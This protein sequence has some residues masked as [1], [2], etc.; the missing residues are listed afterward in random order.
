MPPLKYNSATSIVDSLKAKGMDSSFAARRALAVTYGVVTKAAD[1]MGTAAQNVA[2]LGKFNGTAP[3]TAPGD[4]KDI[5]PA[6][7][8][9][10]DT[11][12]DANSYI[13]QDQGADF[14]AAD[15]VDAPPTRNTVYDQLKNDLEPD[16]APPERPSLLS[17][18]EAERE[19]RGITGL[20][21]QLVDLDARLADEEAR[22]R[23]YKDSVH[24]EAISAGAMAGRISEDERAYRENVDFIQRTRA[25]V[26]NELNT[27]NNA[28]EIVM[29]LTEKDYEMAKE[30]YEDEFDRNLQL[31]SEVNDRENDAQD[32]A[33]ATL[34]ILYNQIA[35]SG[36]DFAS[37]TD[38]QRLTI[39]QLE[40]QAGLP[41]G[42][43]TKVATGTGGGKILSTT[44]RTTGGYKYADVLTRHPDGSISVQSIGLGAD[45]SGNGDGD[46]LSAMEKAQMFSVA[47]QAI[48][49][50]FGD[51]G[52]ANPDTYMAV[53]SEYGLYG[54]VT[55]FDKRFRHLLSLD[56]Q[57][58]LRVTETLE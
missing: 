21:D 45:K 18:Y 56:N 15:S 40:I 54:D 11:N 46:T 12:A 49:D 14:D 41:I 32:N 58:S 9:P 24:T 26:V 50:S 29:S 28:L 47:D 27:K 34:Q 23:Q 13:N 17:T 57:E 2:L 16:Q 10:V 31:Y 42:F 37:L 43:S 36:V 7:D 30:E 51:D 33:R 4:A 22:F 48:R 19:A 25:R 55:E 39:S 38:S 8:K 52:Y 6:T 53:R 5:P 44:T 3:P 20:E 35:E 1:Y